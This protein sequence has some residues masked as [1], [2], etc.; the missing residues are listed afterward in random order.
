MTRGRVIGLM[1]ALVALAAATAATAAAPT[2]VRLSGHAAGDNDSIVRVSTVPNRDGETKVV[3]RFRFKKVLAD[4]DGTEQRISLRLTGRIPVTDRLYKRSF[5]DD[6][7]G[8]VKV[9]GR[10]SRDGNRTSG[11]VRSSAV[12]I[13]GL[14]FCTLPPTGFSARA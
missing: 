8:I 3:K 10:V 5:G 13:D 14:G 9:S 1:A 7:T 4:C 11:V 12:A 6:A 2:S